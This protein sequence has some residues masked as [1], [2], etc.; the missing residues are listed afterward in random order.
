MLTKVS[1]SRLSTPELRRPPESLV[2][3]QALTPAAMYDCLALAV[4]P[5]MRISTMIN[6]HAVLDFSL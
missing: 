2:Q 1:S 4:E 3:S 5:Q 6:R